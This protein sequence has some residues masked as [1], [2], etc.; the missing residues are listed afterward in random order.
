M[1]SLP[2]PP[3]SLKLILAWCALPWWSQKNWI[4]IL[5]TM[6]NIRRIKKREEE[7]GKNIKESAKRHTCRHSV[8]SCN[9]VAPTALPSNVCSPSEWIL[10]PLFKGPL[11]EKWRSE[12]GLLDK[13][14]G[15]FQT[16]HFLMRGK[17]LSGKIGWENFELEVSAKPQKFIR[18]DS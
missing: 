18:A 14:Q 17:K 15:D 10:T 6:A 12:C 2:Q 4:R 8:A 3:R 16:R 11:N 13:G 1:P 7:E 9:G 5:Q